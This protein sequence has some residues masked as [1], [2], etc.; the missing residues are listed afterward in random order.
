MT[1]TFSK[2]TYANFFLAVSGSFTGAPD[3]TYRI[4]FFTDETADASGLGEG[5]SF[6]SFLM[7]TTDANGLG[8]VS[9]SFESVLQ[10]L[11][12]PAFVS[13]TITEPD[14][15]TSRFS[16]DVAV[17]ATEF[18]GLSTQSTTI[19]STGG[20]ISFGVTRT[21]SFDG[22]VTVD[23]STFAAGSFN[24]AVAGTD[25]VPVSGTLTF[26]PG[27]MSKVF[28]VTVLDNTIASESR[29]LGVHLA[30][31][32]G[33][34]VVLG[35]STILITIQP[36][37]QPAVFTVSPL[38]GEFPSVDSTL[39]FAV[40]R[41]GGL[42]RI[43]TV[44]YSAGGGTAIPGVD[45]MP[46]TGTLTFNP[47]DTV[48]VVRHCEKFSPDFQRPDSFWSNEACSTLIH[49]PYRRCHHSGPI[50]RQHAH[51]PVPILDQ[52]NLAPGQP[53]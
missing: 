18:L 45:Y 43:A 50:F 40:H 4:E 6:Q 20:T 23:Y 41:T 30:N 35:P 9:T 52:N 17:A 3:S 19:P 10:S 49:Q 27:E 51:R 32:T 31:L 46:L 14:G 13:A 7:V 42:D 8:A 47:G 36:A 11:N 21:G 28:N 2:V 33:A 5:E 44:D 22:T 15:T 29:I 24:D 39:D 25:Y 37:P 53:L 26:A 48:E 12:A 1:L 16:Q 34:N 38:T